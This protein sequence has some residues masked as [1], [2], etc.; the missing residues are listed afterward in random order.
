MMNKH[1]MTVCD[2]TTNPRR[3]TVVDMLA[4]ISVTKPLVMVIPMLWWRRWNLLT[5]LSAPR[6]L[7]WLPNK[8]QQ[9][10]IMFLQ[11]TSMKQLKNTTGL[12]AMAHKH[13]RKS[14]NPQVALQMLPETNMSSLISSRSSKLVV[15]KGC[16]SA[17]DFRRKYDTSCH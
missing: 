16:C 9:Q 5:W 3:S 2:R 15:L 13:I 10:W 4:N 14:H 6:C 7:I 12:L 8:N 1:V 17:M 11:N